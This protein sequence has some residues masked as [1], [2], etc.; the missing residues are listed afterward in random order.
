[1]WFGATGPAPVRA[2]LA[3][4]AAALAGIA[5]VFHAGQDSSRTPV[6]ILQG[7]RVSA[8]LDLEPSGWPRCRLLLSSPDRAVYGR[9]LQFVQQESRP[10]E[11][12]LAMPNDAELYFLADRPSPVRFYNSALGIRT[13]DELAAVIQRL[14]ADPPRVLIFRPDDKYNTDRSR[15]VLD[16]LRSRYDYKGRIAGRDLY[17]RSG[18][19]GKF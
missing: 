14:D 8:G 15:A 5:V 9:L 2:V 10:G 19:A 3:A 12:I 13:P 16:H 6:E 1:M 7:V 18:S 11:P 17:V 4:G